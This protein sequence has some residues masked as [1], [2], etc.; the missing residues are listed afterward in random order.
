EDGLICEDDNGGRFTFPSTHD[1]C[2]P[3]HCVDRTKN[4]DETDVDCGGS[5]GICNP[6]CDGTPG[7]RTF[8]TYHCKCGIGAGDCDSDEHC[9]AGTVC[10]ADIGARFGADQAYDFCVPTTCNNLM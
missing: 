6:T 9:T 4:G 1:V 5:C 2:V 10:K 7:S 8:C 3:P